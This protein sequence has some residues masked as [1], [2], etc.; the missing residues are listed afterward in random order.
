MHAGRVL[1][2]DGPEEV[3]RKRRV[4]TLD[5]TFI[6]HLLAAG[7]I[8]ARNDLLPTDGTVSASSLHGTDKATL[9]NRSAPSSSALLPKRTE[10]EGSSVRSFSFGRAWS[11]SL[12]ETL[13][14]TRELRATMA[15]LGPAILMIVVGFGISLNVEN[16]TV[17]CE[18]VRSR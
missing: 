9:L 5:E 6:S 12:R 1:V 10:G 2:T 18:P 13:E 14:L 15:L 16:L 7:E 11:Y 4:N 8:S 3:V 17:A